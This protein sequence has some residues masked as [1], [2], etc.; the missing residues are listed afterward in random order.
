MQP[1]GWL[2][3]TADLASCACAYARHARV[4]QA[5]AQMWSVGWG[6]AAIKAPRL[7]TRSEVASVISPLEQSRLVTAVASNLGEL[8]LHGDGS[9][10]GARP[11]RQALC[12]HAD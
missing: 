9:V 12:N 2:D 11:S 8:T 4:A 1:I 6:L 3:A 7:E 5:N 10:G